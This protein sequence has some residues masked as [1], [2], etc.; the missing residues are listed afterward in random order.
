MSIEQLSNKSF[1]ETAISVGDF[2]CKETFKSVI[3]LLV[4]FTTRKTMSIKVKTM[5]NLVLFKMW[6]SPGSQ[7]SARYRAKPSPAARHESGLLEQ[8]C[9]VHTFRFDFERSIFTALCC[10]WCGDIWMERNAVSKFNVKLT[11]KSQL[12]PCCAQFTCAAPALS[13]CSSVSQCFQQTVWVTV[14]IYKTED[15]VWISG[16]SVV[17]RYQ[18]LHKNL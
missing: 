17:S 10:M 5:W 13:T 12:N 4:H 14:W 1:I 18:I 2:F 3:S 11:R 7:T 16:Q 6:F 8:G 15:K 9:I